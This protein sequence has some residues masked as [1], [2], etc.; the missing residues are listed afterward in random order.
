METKPQTTTY[1][2]GAMDLFTKLSGHPA[3]RSVQGSGWTFV[4]GLASPREFSPGGYEKLIRNLHERGEPYWGD[5]I[6]AVDEEVDMIAETVIAELARRGWKWLHTAVSGRTITLWVAKTTDDR[7]FYQITGTLALEWAR[8]LKDLTK[9]DRMASPS[10]SPDQGSFITWQTSPSYSVLTPDGAETTATNLWLPS[11]EMLKVL[12]VPEEHDANDGDALLNKRAVLA[13]GK[14]CDIVIKTGELDSLQFL[15]SAEENG[16]KAMGQTEFRVPWPEGWEEWD[17]LIGAEGILPNT[18]RKLTMGKATA[19]Y[20][21]RHSYGLV[22]AD[23]LETV[24]NGYSRYFSA[25]TLVTYGRAAAKAKLLEQQVKAVTMKED[26]TADWHAEEQAEPAPYS[27][28]PNPWAQVNEQELEFGLAARQAY[29]SV[30]AHPRSLG[31]QA[32][33]IANRIRGMVKKNTT[34]RDGRHGMPGA[35]IPGSKLKL[36]HWFFGGTREPDWGELAVGWRPDGSP[37]LYTINPG[38]WATPEHGFCSDGDDCDDMEN[39]VAGAEEWDGPVKAINVRTPSSPGGGEHFD[40][41]PDGD[42]WRRYSVVLPLKEGWGENPPNLHAQEP[43]FSMGPEVETQQATHDLML[44]LQACRFSAG[45]SKYIGQF[46]DAL[47][48][49]YLSGVPANQLAYRG[50]DLMDNIWNQKYDGAHAVREV[51]M[52]CVERVRAN[53]PWFE[54]VYGRIA[55]AVNDLHEELYQTKAQPTFGKYPEWEAIFD[56][57]LG[58]NDLTDL[59]DLAL[60]YRCNGPIELLTQELDERIAAIGVALALEVEKEWDSW[61]K[62]NNAISRAKGVRRKKREQQR[63]DLTKATLDRI[64]GWTDRAYEKAREGDYVPG[65]LTTAIRQASIALGKRWDAPQNGRYRVMP[66]R[67]ML[68]K[69]ER[70]LLHGLPM[71]EIQAHYRQGRN[72]EPS[73]ITRLMPSPT[74]PDLLPGDHVYVERSESGQFEL[75]SEVGGEL[76]GTLR[77][78]GYGMV[79]LSAQFVGWLHQYD[80]I[81]EAQPEFYRKDPIALFRHRHREVLGALQKKSADATEELKSMSM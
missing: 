57:L 12:S 45:Q 70:K 23:G 3:I 77:H 65:D 59:L 72:S 4:K 37:Y 66:S 28:E 60:A 9:R 8:L 81:A 43:A 49:L 22:F 21:S 30:F 73:W 20:P 29:G 54:P 26:R 64:Q 31:L 79:G 6:I 24:P 18:R 68:P 71:A 38:Q 75:R 62:S 11:G 33:G 53:K 50:S 78:E 19:R 34:S 76:I 56:G 46:A 44:I 58:T 47:Q 13:L 7:S 67:L 63:R 5:A 48:A 52:F 51:H 16:L 1:G 36:A 35:I 14:S 39:I 15:I 42:R 25:E 55:R 41:T 32:R 10:N 2:D 27:D 69:A 80:R 17:I 61:R 74:E 40:M